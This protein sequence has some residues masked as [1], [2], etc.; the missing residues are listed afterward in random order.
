MR[1]L[2]SNEVKEKL[3]EILT[4]FADFCDENKLQYYICGGTL[5]G[6]VRHKDFIPWD[7]DI[8]V[9]MPRPDYTRLCELMRGK[10]VKQHYKL[11]SFEY[12]N[13]AYPIS[14]FIDEN[15]PADPYYNGID[16]YLWIDVF[17]MDGLPGNEKEDVDYLKK[18]GKVKA[19]FGLATTK[20]LS[21][22]TKRKIVLSFPFKLFYH[23]IGR[24]K[25][26]MQLDQM[27]KAYPFD[28]SDYIAGIAWANGPRERVTRS[29]FVPVI[30]LEFHGRK[31]HSPAGYDEYLT[32]MY[33]D[34]MQLPP[35]SK[36]KNHKITVFCDKE[37][38]G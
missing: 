2:N 3:F 10:E 30:D 8:D 23:M 5:L 26:A 12:G 7:D 36:R 9:L 17:P 27:A 21:G 33:G 18:V 28:H 35:E 13:L 4:V 11:I 1:K 16:R 22:S 25:Y 15:L 19:R 34:Y 14:K 29:K 31:F 32:N 37:N 24:E 38:W 20:L 6:A